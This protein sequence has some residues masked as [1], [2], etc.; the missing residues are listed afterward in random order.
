MQE[1]TLKFKK[2]NTIIKEEVGR[3]EEEEKKA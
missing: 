2:N 3:N 1:I